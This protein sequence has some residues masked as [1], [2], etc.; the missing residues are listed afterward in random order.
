MHYAPGPDRGEDEGAKAADQNPAAH[1][2]GRG[3]ERV[4]P[5]GERNLNKLRTGR[6]LAGEGFS[7][8]SKPL[9]GFPRGRKGYPVPGLGVVSLRVE[10]AEILIRSSRMKEIFL[11][12]ELR[13]CQPLGWQGRGGEAALQEG[14]GCTT[15]TNAVIP[16]Q[17]DS[18]SGPS[19][20][21]ARCEPRLAG[22]GLRL[23]A[24]GLR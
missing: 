11:I 7:A 5:A 21:G 15:G 22:A 14:G 2:S 19:C 17:S 3:Y 6:R 1:P 24:P 13:E 9:A 23:R 8:S 20:A 18:G 12:P 10:K 4:C 16:H